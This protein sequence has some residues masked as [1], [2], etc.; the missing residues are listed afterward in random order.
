L[1]R[2]HSLRFTWTESARQFLDNIEQSRPPRSAP[3]KELA[4]SD[5]R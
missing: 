4:L 3:I 2:E 5:Y 1:P